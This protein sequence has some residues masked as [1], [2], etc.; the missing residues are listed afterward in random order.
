MITRSSATSEETASATH[1][2]VVRL[3]S[4]AVS[5]ETYACR[6]NPAPPDKSAQLRRQDLVRGGTKLMTHRNT[7]KLRELLYSNCGSD[8]LEYAGYAILVLLLDSQL[9]GVKCQSLC[10]SEI[11]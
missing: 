9:H 3:L 1:F 4:I 11:T 6:L 7:V 10:G 5:T 8:V 2:V